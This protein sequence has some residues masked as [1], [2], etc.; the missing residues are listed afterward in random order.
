MCVHDDCYGSV[1]WA[2]LMPDVPMDKKPSISDFP[3]NPEVKVRKRY[4]KKKTK[5]EE[6]FPTY[7]QVQPTELWEFKFLLSKIWTPPPIHS[8]VHKAPPPRISVAH[9]R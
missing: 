4:R 8:H 2:D 7:L 6:A 1:G 5:L 3:E 9:S